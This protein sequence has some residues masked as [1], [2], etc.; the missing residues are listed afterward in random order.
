LKQNK[1]KMTSAQ[2][3]FV[4]HMGQQMVGWNLPRT[5]GRVWAYLLMRGEPAAL[6][7]IAR[8]LDVAKSGASVGARQLVAFGLARST[9]ERGSRRVLFSAIDNMDA[10]FAARS[11]TARAVMRLLNEGARVASTSVTRGKLREM[12]STVDEI[13]ERE[14]AA[15]AARSRKGRRA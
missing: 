13:L 8:D 11:E 9:G 4:D 1:A 15:I 10:M 7:D 12:A 5:T 6:D 3:D 14:S 2:H